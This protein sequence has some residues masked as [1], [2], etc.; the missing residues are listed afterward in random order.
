[1]TLFFHQFSHN[2]VPS[3]TT[4]T[5][6]T[7]SYDNSRTLHWVSECWQSFLHKAYT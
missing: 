7:T 3:Q 1:M 2:A 6:K 5:D 4:T